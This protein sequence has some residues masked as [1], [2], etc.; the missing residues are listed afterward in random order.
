[1]K[2]TLCL[3]ARLSP[4]YIQKD[5]HVANVTILPLLASIQRLTVAVCMV[6]YVVKMPVIALRNV[7]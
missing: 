1:M 7:H 6:Y 2:S 3:V 4:I 5:H